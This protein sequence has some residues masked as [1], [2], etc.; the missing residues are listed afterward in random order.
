[1]TSCR[2]FPHIT[3]SSLFLLSVHFSLGTYAALLLIFCDAAKEN[4]QRLSCCDYDGVF[5]QRLAFDHERAAWLEVEGGAGGPASCS[6]CLKGTPEG[7]PS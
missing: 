2:S 5:A 3:P 4:K 1:M 6:L 7:A